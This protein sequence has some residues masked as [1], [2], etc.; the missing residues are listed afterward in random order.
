MVLGKF[1]L[2]FAVLGFFVLALS[3]C[4]QKSSEASTPAAL[5]PAT[6][7]ASTVTDSSLESFEAS[8]DE[9]SNADS[10][11]DALPNEFDASLLN[12]P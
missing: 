1:L 6:T 4:V 2:V 12:E 9:A 3:G 8:L 10:E 11:L 5:A 7:G